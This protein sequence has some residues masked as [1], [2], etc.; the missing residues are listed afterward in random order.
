MPAHQHDHDHDRER[1]AIFDAELERRIALLDGHESE[2]PDARELPRTDRTVLG[3]LTIGSL[4]AVW[5]VQ[6]L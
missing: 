4:V 1:A 3:V 6:A 5:L 2:P